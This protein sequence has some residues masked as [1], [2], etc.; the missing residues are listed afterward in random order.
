MPENV[1]IVVILFVVLFVVATNMRHTRTANSEK[2]EARKQQHARRRRRIHTPKAS[3]G[4][5][6]PPRVNTDA[7]AVGVIADLVNDYRHPIAYTGQRESV[8]PLNQSTDNAMFDTHPMERQSMPVTDIIQP[9]RQRAIASLSDFTG[10]P[11]REV[12]ARIR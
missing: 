6:L 3:D 1:A 2:F 10:K 5:G 9:I 4:F 7:I 12:V 8:L 11:G